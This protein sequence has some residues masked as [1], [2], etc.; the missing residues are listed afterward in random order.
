MLVLAL[1][2]AALTPDP[3]KEIL[4][5][6]IGVQRFEVVLAERAL[7]T[8][9]T[10]RRFRGLV[11]FFN[12]PPEIPVDSGLTTLP[13]GRSAVRFFVSYA[14]LP[15]D[16]L[17]RSR[18]DRIDYQLT[19]QMSSGSRAE[20]FDSKGSIARENVQLNESMKITLQRFVRVEDVSLG[21]VGVRQA[22]VSVDVDVLVP[23]SFDLRFLEASCEVSV[24]DKPLAS[25]RREKF[26]LHAGRWNRLRIP[27]ALDYGALLKVAGRTASSR[28]PIQGQL[29]GLARLRIPS[30]SLDFPFAFPVKLSLG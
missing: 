5:G 26:I 28:G 22:T 23:L 14:A 1:A 16:L 9:E 15:Q 19:G 18:L 2:L 27:V 30:G 17:E 10:A 7:P 12:G 29:T 11:R 21:R 25:G 6:P 24:A 3:T 4:I 20:P 8:P 13:G